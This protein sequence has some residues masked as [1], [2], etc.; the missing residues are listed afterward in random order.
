MRAA[1]GEG[2]L[3]YVEADKAAL[4]AGLPLRSVPISSPAEAVAD[5][6]T[7]RRGL[8]LAPWLLIAALLA[9]LVEGLIAARGQ[10]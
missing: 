1:P 9:W 10:R 4:F 6:R 3:R 2:L 5:W 8:D 7:Q